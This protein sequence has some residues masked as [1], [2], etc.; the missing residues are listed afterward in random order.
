ML[1][2]KGSQREE[3]R[4]WDLICSGVSESLLTVRMFEPR[5]GRYVSAYRQKGGG[6]LPEE[7]R[8]CAKVAGRMAHLGI[9]NKPHE[10]E[11]Q[12]KR[13]S[14]SAWGSMCRQEPDHA[15]R[16]WPGYTCFPRVL[17]T[18]AWILIK[19]DDVIR[20]KF[21]KTILITVWK[22]FWGGWKCFWG[23]PSGYHCSDL[24]RR[25][26]WPTWKWWQ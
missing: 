13:E 6:N 12:K 26:F 10:T 9:W 19:G 17:E 16:V 2:K 23:D 14:S 18:H 20:F 1:W 4:Y 11:V 24:D 8:E 5:F 21:W 7:E 22:M 15:Q 25:L 3:T